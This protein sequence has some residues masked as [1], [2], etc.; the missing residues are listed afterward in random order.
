[1]SD[2][3]KE[4]IYLDAALGVIGEQIDERIDEL[5]RRR[6]GRSRVGVAVLAIAT[7]AS[8]SLAAFAITSA[9]G[10]A[11]PDGPALTRNVEVHCIDGEDAEEAAYFTVR[12]R[13][14][15]TAAGDPARVCAGARSLLISDDGTIAAGAPTEIVRIASDVVPAAAKRTDAAASAV[16]VEEASFGRLSAVGGPNMIVCETGDLAIV[17]AT[18]PG[19]VAPGDQPLLCARATR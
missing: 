19:A 15:Q 12:Y 6:R 5:A 9:G 11:A 17:L 1:M 4:G 2:R 8:S 14:A 7:V 16:R 3:P 10:G 13:A 18:V